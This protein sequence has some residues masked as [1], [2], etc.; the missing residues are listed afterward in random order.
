M[1]QRN[2]ALLLFLFGVICSCEE[3]DPPATVDRTPK[4]LILAQ[5]IAEDLKATSLENAHSHSSI[6]SEVQ[7][8]ADVDV[9][10]DTMEDAERVSSQVRAVFESAGYST[11][12]FSE[13]S[14]GF[15][16][17]PGQKDIGKSAWSN[18]GDSHFDQS[19]GIDRHVGADF[20]GS[21]DVQNRERLR[22]SGVFW[23]G[24]AQVF[25]HLWLYPEQGHC[26]ASLSITNKS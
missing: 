5:A 19:L 8:T 23:D 12:F 3:S 9:K 15:D 17:E 4:L 16:R 22:L 14:K 2:L 6:H 25:L 7:M 26:Y 1:R 20:S 24:E 11:M 10:F 21:S 13:F 18:S